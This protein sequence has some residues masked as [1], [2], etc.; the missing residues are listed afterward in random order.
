MTRRKDVQTA[1]D[2]TTPRTPASE[3]EVSAFL[4]KVAA[5]P[6]PAEAG[7]RGRVLFALDATASRQPTWDRAAAVQGRMFEAAAALGGLD[8]QLAFYRGFREFKVSRWTDRGGELARLMAG[9]GCM[10]GETQIAKVLGHAVNEA[11]AGR[12]GALIFVGDCCEED[13]DKLG[14]RAGELGLLGVP[15]FIFHE[16]N[17]PIAAFAFEQIAK[18][19]GGACCRFDAD[20]PDQLAQ[21]L[22]AVAV[23]AAGGR[24][25]LEA[26]AK[27]TGGA[28]ALLTDRMAGR[29][30]GKGG[31]R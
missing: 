22:G 20:S 19:S 10:A 12:L 4:D 9:V 28:A 16:G 21:L 23:Y 6:K 13:V 1:A 2:A 18:L 14:A 25:A 29:S 17:D 30:P 3:S 11:K 7:A 8:I 27:S 5:A 24:P 15:A 26:H 31:G